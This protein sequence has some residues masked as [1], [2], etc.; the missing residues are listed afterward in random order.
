MRD[1]SEGCGL[2]EDLSKFGHF[3]PWRQ[4][5]SCV[6][7]LFLHQEIVRTA[8]YGCERERGSAVLSWWITGA[9]EAR[10]F[11]VNTSVRTGVNLLISSTTEKLAGYLQAV[12]TRSLRGRAS[13]AVD[14]RS[15]QFWGIARWYKPKFQEALDLSSLWCSESSL[16]FTFCH[17]DFE[18]CRIKIH[19]PISWQQSITRYSSQRFLITEKEAEESFLQTARYYWI[20]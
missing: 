19:T 1:K 6:M 3:Y 7:Q 13:S 11:N 12:V 9:G 4:R 16:N 20:P 8:N 17:K 18:N 10:G 14:P 15:R 2:L 5:I